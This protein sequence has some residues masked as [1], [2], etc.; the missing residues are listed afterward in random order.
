MR[1]G[2]FISAIL[3]NVLTV[4]AQDNWPLGARSAAMAN[5]SV[6]LTDLWAVHHNQAALADL[7]QAGVGVYYENR[8]LVKD[9]SMQGAAVAI[10]TFKVGTFGVS[11]SRFGNNLYNDN[12]VGLAYGMKLF[13]FLS[14]GVQLN[15][16]NTYLAENYGSK[17]NFVVELGVLSQVTKNFRVGFH[18]Y[19]LSRASLSD[20]YATEYVPMIF[21]LGMQYD[22]S[23]K[24]RVALEADKDMVLPPV[25]KLGV[26]YLPS[27]VIQ[28][29]VGAATQPFQA[30]FGFGVRFKGIHFDVAG[31]VHP[32]LGFSPMGSLSYNFNA[33][34]QP[35][36]KEKVKDSSSKSKAKK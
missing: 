15:Y 26:E 5:A 20:R 21:R 23:Q 22:F 8:F 13:K 29:R 4:Q 14:A 36:D 33:F 2:L 32:V 3:V 30:T 18:A 11:W 27:E 25:V 24:V 12:R 34:K 35:K 17:G 9:M 7:R 19:N 1:L 16:L 31:S 10:P 28:I 6:C